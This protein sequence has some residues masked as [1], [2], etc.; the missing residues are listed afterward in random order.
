MPEV[1]WRTKQ[2]IMNDLAASYLAIAQKDVNDLNAGTV[3]RTLLEVVAE[4]HEE[5]DY[6]IAS[7]MYR[8]SLR[9]AQGSDLDN[10]GA[11]EGLTRHGA[12]G[13]SGLVRLSRDSAAPSDS[14]VVP[15]GGVIIT[16]GRTLYSNDVAIRI[17]TGATS[18][19][20]DDGLWNNID[21]PFTATV[22]GQETNSGANTA[23]RITQGPGGIDTVS[24][25]TV[26]SGGRLAESD[27]DFRA[28]IS[29][30]RDR[31][32]GGSRIALLAEILRAPEVFSA[33]VY[34]WA[35]MP[36]GSKFVKPS[37]GEVWAYVYGVFPATASFTVGRSSNDP[38]SAYTL[39]PQTLVERT[40]NNLEPI[41]AFPIALKVYE[42]Y[43]VLVNV[44]VTITLAKS[45]RV[46]DTRNIATEIQQ[47]IRNYLLQLKIG[48]SLSVGHIYLLIGQLLPFK[49]AAVSF[50][51]H[52][53]RTHEWT[54]TITDG[55]VAVE[56]DE[57]LK[58]Y[59]SYLGFGSIT[60]QHEE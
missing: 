10:I 54:E 25:V 55:L 13:A 23:T 16:N 35:I 43:S 58:P 60:I 51:V 52:R 56:F 2:G 48:E 49:T 11:D 47:Q 33:A 41:R 14:A 34:E 1:R 37:P 27:Y 24:N 36:S 50:E 18:W 17:F 30:E 40:R 57:I 20:I 45:H 53:N 8:A 12:L 9:F 38:A 22:T 6:Q 29:W 3:L 26:F 4:E 21:I 39:N 7:S 15:V 28:R 59:G 31:K 46:A 42:A 44:I 32:R 19:V 5:T